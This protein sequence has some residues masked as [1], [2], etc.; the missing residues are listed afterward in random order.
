MA[1]FYQH[2]GREMWHRDG[3]RSIGT[4]DGG[5][6]RFSFADIQPFLDA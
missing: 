5:L 3:L 2:I 1:I 6:R 4:P